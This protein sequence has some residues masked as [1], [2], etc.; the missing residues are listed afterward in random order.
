MAPMTGALS[1]VWLAEVEAEYL[2]L[3]HLGRDVAADVGDQ[4]RTFQHLIE[5][6]GDASARPVERAGSANVYVL[7]GSRALMFYAIAGSQ[8]AVVKWTTLGTEHQQ[9]VAQEQA[10]QR[11]A[12]RFP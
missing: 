10:I 1:D 11:A 2:A 12:H 9:R 3:L 4:F 8:A 5:R 7:Y 6:G